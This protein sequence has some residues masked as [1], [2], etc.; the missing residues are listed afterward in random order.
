MRW[1]GWHWVFWSSQERIIS[2]K[3]CNVLIEVCNGKSYV[4]LITT[5]AAAITGIVVKLYFVSR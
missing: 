1:K 4:L 3:I 2:Q 5:A